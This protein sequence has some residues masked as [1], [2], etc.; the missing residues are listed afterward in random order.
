MVAVKIV[1]ARREGKRVLGG[2]IQVVLLGEGTERAHELVA[3]VRRQ[4]GSGVGGA[5]K[6]HGRVL[7]GGGS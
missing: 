1:L 7:L 6:G 3:L 2:Q 5:F 4:F